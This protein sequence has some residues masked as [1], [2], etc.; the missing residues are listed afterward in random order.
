MEHKEE[1]KMEHMEEHKEQVDVTK[2]RYSQLN[3]PKFV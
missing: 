2:L 3:E 1:H